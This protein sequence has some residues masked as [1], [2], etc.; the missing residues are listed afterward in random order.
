MT[1]PEFARPLLADKIGGTSR[2]HAIEAS[3]SECAAVAERLGCLD[4]SGFTARFAA[5]AV[6]G[7][8]R[9]AGTVEAKVSVPCVVT[10]QPVEQPIQTRFEALFL[11]PG[12]RSL[13]EEVELSAEDCD[14][15]ELAGGAIDLGECAV[16]ALAVAIDYT[17]RA[18]GAEAAAAAKGILDEEAA[19][20]LANPFSLVNA[21]TDNKKTPS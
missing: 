5:E 18:P 10:L 7:G 1:A 8:F 16:Q 21:L 2:I 20:R 14:I 13:A 15:E 6:A 11:P 12:E 4:I 3:A 19:R 9:I 17:P